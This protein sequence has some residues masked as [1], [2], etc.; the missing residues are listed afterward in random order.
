MESLSITD[1]LWNTV[2]AR[3]RAYLEAS[4]LLLEEAE[5]L[6]TSGEF[7]Q[8]AEKFWGAVAQAV[9]AIAEE[10]GWEHYRHH[11]LAEAISRLVAETGDVELSLL[12]AS[13]ERLHANFY[14]GFMTEAEV[15]AH[16]ENA[17][18]LITKLRGL[19]ASSGQD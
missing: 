18:K 7:R 13:A 19:L 2:K 12:Y 11:H 14:E 9:K 17:R 3:T 4:E 15:R 6:L 16:A 10:R 5:E 8:A 1:C